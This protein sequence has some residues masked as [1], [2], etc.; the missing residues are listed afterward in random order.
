MLTET[1]A[2]LLEHGVKKRRRK[3]IMFLRGGSEIVIVETRSTNAGAR[4]RCTQTLRNTTRLEKSRVNNW[5]KL[6]THNSS[7]RW[8][9]L[10]QE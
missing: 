10:S 2:G 6:L 7:T 8:D 3:T 5:K 9:A 1:L 4:R